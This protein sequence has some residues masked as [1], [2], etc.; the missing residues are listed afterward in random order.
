LDERDRKPVWPRGAKRKRV[1][2]QNS[3]KGN[4]HRRVDE[5][6]KNEVEG[7][8]ERLVVQELVVSVREI[9]GFS[10]SNS[11]F[12]VALLLGLMRKVSTHTGCS[13]IV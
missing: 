2:S 13:L 7:D 1:G 8:E 6:G 5:E 12:P 3:P 11:S 10:F 9:S 4:K